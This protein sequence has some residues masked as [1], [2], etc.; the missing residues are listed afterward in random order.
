MADGSAAGRLLD[1]GAEDDLENTVPLLGIFDAEELPLADAVARTGALDK[2][3]TV[4]AQ[5]AR[6][7]LNSERTNAR[8]PAKNIKQRLPQKTTRGERLW[9]RG[10]PLGR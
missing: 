7:V 10:L 2:A 3:E 8:T 4:R 1:V 5:R 6:S 9:R